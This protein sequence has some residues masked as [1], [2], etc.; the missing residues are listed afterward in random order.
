MLK[1]IL[2]TVGILL[3]VSCLP[4]K[5]DGG[6]QQGGA[7]PKCGDLLQDKCS[8]SSSC[9]WTGTQCSG[10]IEY[11]GKFTTSNSCPSLSCQWSQSGSTCRPFSSSNSIP[12]DTCGNYTQSTCD[13]VAGCAWNGMKCSRTGGSFPSSTCQNYYSPNECSAV[14]GCR[15]DGM[16]CLSSS[17]GLPSSTC[18]NYYSPNEC[19]AV[20]GCMWDGMKCNSTGGL[21]SGQ[22]AGLQ[23][24]QCLMSANCNYFLLPQPHCG[25]AR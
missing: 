2:V 12:T 20:P 24:F 3:M 6:G 9:Q 13:M 7:D 19:S 23:V 15:W 1:R 11:C 17:G 21:P 8:M 18:Q 10:S 5:K 25:D 4:P 22:C 14:P 16:K